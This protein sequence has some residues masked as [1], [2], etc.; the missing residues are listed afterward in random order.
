MD[1]V[2]IESPDKLRA[3]PPP[4]EIPFA[5][6]GDQ[7]LVAWDDIPGSTGSIIIPETARRPGADGTDKFLRFG[8]V[9]K[10]GPGE[11][12]IGKLCPCGL[13]C[14]RR[15][16]HP[17]FG[18]CRVCGKTEWRATPEFRLPFDCKVGDH[19]LYDHPSDREVTFDGQRYVVLHEEQHVWMIL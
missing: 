11:R 6:T 3:F 14:E 5:P 7:I 10:L 16:S 4:D 19:I 2:D 18:K 17:Q 12:M 8:T 1:H 15:A 9:T 13:T